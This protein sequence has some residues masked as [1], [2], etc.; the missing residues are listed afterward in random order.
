MKFLFLFFYMLI[1]NINFTEPFFLNKGY[2]KR[3]V[4]S[5]K[6]KNIDDI[7]LNYLKDYNKLDDKDNKYGGLL[8]SNINKNNFKIFKKNYDK[9]DELNK[10]LSE[11]KNTFEL[12][13]N[14][15]FDNYLYNDPDPNL[16][17]K[18][19]PRN[20]KFK[21][22]YEKY[23]KDPFLYISKFFFLKKEFSWNNT[24]FLSPVKN[25][26]RCGSCWAFATTNALETY[27][28]SL[29]YTIDRLSEQELVDCSWQNYGCNGGFMH[30]AFDFIIE[31]KG[32]VS[33]KEYPYNARTNKCRIPKVDNIHHNNTD[34]CCDKDSCDCNNCSLDDENKELLN[35]N[36][37]NGSYLKE[38][39][40]TIPKSVID[41]MLS[42]KISPITIAVD[43]SSIYFR[44]YKSGVIDIETNSTQ[45]LNH[46][47]LLIG[48]GFDENGLYWIIQNSWGKEWGD[49][50]FCKIRVK[51]GDGI[52]LS[53]IY[54]VYPSK[55]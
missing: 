27:M 37:V 42:L 17:N 41:R 47:V 52:L 44:Y 45:Q 23:I 8:G 25:Q 43:A 26:G 34:S 1:C 21:K 30:K 32:L 46:A 22:S 28:R 24:D 3:F 16:M 7:Y 4:M 36:K 9:I 18:V 49:N 54:G 31:N 53:N 29:N 35:L 15:D 39:E 5:N 6:E 2:F 20:Y 38:Y 51:D 12:G 50:G 55:I 19:I 10:E 13:F 40:F 14:S 33:D 48:Y 11:N